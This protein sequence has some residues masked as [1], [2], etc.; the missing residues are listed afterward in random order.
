MTTPE[1]GG[2]SRVRRAARVVA[3]IPVVGAGVRRASALGRRASRSP[4]PM[5]VQARRAY[6]T[7][8]TGG[9]LDL[10]PASVGPLGHDAAATPAVEALMSRGQDP[11]DRLRRLRE[12]RDELVRSHAT[13]YELVHA[14][15]EAE[16]AVALEAVRGGGGSNPGGDGP[17]VLDARSW[18]DDPGADAVLLLRAVREAAGAREV[19]ALVGDADTAAVKGVA[20]GAL[21]DASLV[22]RVEAVADR[23][24]RARPSGLVV[25]DVLGA[26]APAVARFAARL[27]CA[28]IG[29]VHDMARW[30]CPRDAADWLRVR[31]RGALLLD[32]DLVLAGDA[33][34]AAGLARWL[35]VPT[36]RIAVLGGRSPEPGAGVALGDRVP[37]VHVLASGRRLDDI[38]CVVT[39][40]ATATAA[41]RAP[42][43]VLVHGAL[44]AGAGERLEA[45]RH[46]LGRHA[47]A[48]EV[49]AGPPPA[50]AAPDVVVDAS[51]DG[52]HVRAAATFAAGAVPV[53]AVRCPASVDVLGD[54]PWLVAPRDHAALADLLRS[55]AGGPGAVAADQ[56]TRAR[57]AA[58]RHGGLVRRA[59]ADALGAVGDDADTAGGAD[60]PPP[61]ATAASSTVSLC[62]PAGGA[63]LDMLLARAD[64]A[65][66]GPA[67]AAVE[68]DAAAA[69][70]GRPV[71]ALDAS[72]LVRSDPG[73]VVVALAD[74]RADLVG[75]AVAEAYGVPVLTAESAFF[76]LHID[77]RGPHATV[78]LVATGTGAPTP[79]EL[80]VLR[81]SGA[82][83]AGTGM[84]DLSRRVRTLLVTSRETQ[85]QVRAEGGEAEAIG[86]PPASS[87][88]AG[89]RPHRADARD[90]LGIDADA[91]VV[92]CLA[93][94]GDYSRT[95]DRVVAAAGWLALWSRPA[96][97][98]LPSWLPPAERDRLAVLAHD[99]GCHRPPVHVGVAGE[100][101]VNLLVGAADVVVALAAGGPGPEDLWTAGAPLITTASRPG[102]ETRAVRVVP[103]SITPL[104]LAEELLHPPA[105]EPGHGG[106]PVPEGRPAAGA[107]WVG[108][109]LAAVGGR[110]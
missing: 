85:A 53:A 104:L 78:P 31:S 21:A 99:L 84:V 26:P 102:D 77:T 64:G 15:L 61:G 88:L 1:A 87:V 45:L 58:Q 80:V 11:Q 3:G 60:P 46:D 97:V 98:L 43:R 71:T 22:D 90:E 72:I 44:P 36:G 16:A 107:D 106:A 29:V 41:D 101:G 59:V 108:Q 55:W 92:S 57:A 67:F 13:P 4:V 27:G 109:V 2:G 32:M 56:A 96:T 38:A 62:A 28:S 17:V 52:H 40:T 65:R 51:H 75:L 8:V 39:A 74:T 7:A 37:A 70:L 25:L 82:R 50:P 73:D 93:R 48:L 14:V 9:P 12:V 79:H 19:V 89:A 63:L 66:S 34:V 94:T 69:V 24:V 54:G 10:S 95:A 33:T 5:S 76:A 110:T 30:E 105:A 49:L 42:R 18:P 20:D 35:G 83:P 23:L 91:L 100:R 86:L 6:L 81:L 68:P 47:P 103:A